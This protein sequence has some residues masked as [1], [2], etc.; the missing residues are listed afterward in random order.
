M[1]E[2]EKSDDPRAM[3]DQSSPKCP[4]RRPRTI[5]RSA[6]RSSRTTSSPRAGR[7][8]RRAPSVTCRRARTTRAADSGR[9][10]GA[11]HAH[12]PEREFISPLPAG[13]SLDNLLSGFFGCVWRTGA[14][15]RGHAATQECRMP[16]SASTRRP[17]RTA[18]AAVTAL[19]LTVLATLIPTQTAAAQPGDRAVGPEI[20]QRVTAPRLVARATLSADYLAP[21]PPSGRMPRRPTAGPVRSP[22]RSFPAS[23]P[24]SPTATAR[25]GPCPTTGS[26]PRTTPRT[27]CC[28]STWSSRAGQRRPAGRA[29]SR[30]G[31]SSACATPTTRSTSRSSTRTPRSGC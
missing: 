26:A 1:S 29:R 25:S 18:I 2:P 10:T 21:G 13:L 6:R 31:A 23:R 22:G 20:R 28:G 9:R 11:A 24:R 27:S 8:T 19:A 12:S 15:T 5:P 7:A 30:S 3:D 16:E 14:P 4:S 17:L